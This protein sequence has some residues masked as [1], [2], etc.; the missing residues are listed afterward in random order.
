MSDKTNYDSLA[1]ALVEQK[2][3]LS[4]LGFKFDS[5]EKSSD[6]LKTHLVSLDTKLDL[7]LEK[8][9]AISE[10][11]AAYREKIKGLEVQVADLDK[12]YESLNKDVVE[13]R[14]SMAQK[15]AYGALGG[16]AITAIIELSKRM[17]GS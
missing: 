8:L 7:L 5:L 3:N 14:V 6:E 4:E 15:L 10:T 17:I 11:G 13:V 2:M 9:A 1:S 12:K 16:G